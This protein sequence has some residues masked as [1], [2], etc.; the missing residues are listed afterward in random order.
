MATRLTRARRRRNRRKA[1]RIGD[2]TYARSAFVPMRTTRTPATLP[3]KEVEN[4]EI[5]WTAV[6]FGFTVGVLAVVAYALA[7]IATMGRRHQH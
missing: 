1:G 6:A 2:Y 5:L 4:M 3:A 7:R